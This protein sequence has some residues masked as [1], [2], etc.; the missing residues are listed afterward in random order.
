MLRV[1]SWGCVCMG[2]QPHSYMKDWSRSTD[3]EC[4]CVPKQLCSLLQQVL[5]IAA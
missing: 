2:E 3:C 1:L 4:L 5:V